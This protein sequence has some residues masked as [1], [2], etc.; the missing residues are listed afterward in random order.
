MFSL[1][2]VSGIV[3]LLIAKGLSVG[4]FCGMY[5]FTGELF[6]TVCRGTTFGYCGFWSRV[7]SLIAPQIVSWTE[8]V[9]PAFPM[10]LMGALLALSG[11][12]LFLL[13]ETLKVEMLNTVQ[14]VDD[15]WGKNK[16]KSES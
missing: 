15:L 11:G 16:N 4:G 3:L 6:P 10:F 5:V 2:D 9:N 1:P 13:P 12:L 14:D 8:L 7:G